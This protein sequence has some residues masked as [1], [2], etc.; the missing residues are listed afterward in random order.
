MGAEAGQVIDENAYQVWREQW[1]RQILLAGERTAI[2]L[3]DILD[4]GGAAK[5]SEGSKV[6]T[7]ADVEKEKEMKEWDKERDRLRR[8]ER[9]ARGN[10]HVNLPVLM[11]NLSIA[12]VT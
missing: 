1:L 11:T 7:N 3:N 6:Q 10:A 5:L 8:L 2:V 9:A 12:A 4:A